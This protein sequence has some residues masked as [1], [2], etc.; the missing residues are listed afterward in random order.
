MPQELFVKGQ[1]PDTFDQIGVGIDLSSGLRE[2]NDY[3][4][5]MLGG[6]LDDK[7]Y[8]IDQRRIRCM[9][10]I[11]KVEALCDLL[12]EW[13]LLIKDEVGHY[14]PTRSDVT[15]W[16]EEV[17]YQKSFQGDFRRIA[18][19]EWGLTNLRVSPVRGVRGDKLARFRGVMGLFETGRVVFNKYRDFRVTFDEIMN[20]GHSPHDDCAD[21]LQILLDR[22]FLRGRVELD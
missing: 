18:F 8:I 12:F 7:A 14:L 1:I 6:R 21:A 22:L 9:G 3:S 2:R 16:P 13:N 19:D 10:N 15:I 4:V 5:F 20:L 11:E 17:S